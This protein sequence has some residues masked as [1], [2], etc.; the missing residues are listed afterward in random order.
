MHYKSDYSNLRK[1]YTL[2]KLVILISFLIWSMNSLLAHEPESEKE[3]A[4]LPDNVF[5]SKEVFFS[6]IHGVGYNNDG[7]SILV[8]SHAGIMLYINGQWIAPDL[9]AHDYMGFAPV[10]EGFYSSGHPALNTDLLNPLG[11]VKVSNNGKE[12]TS[13]AF[14]GVIDFHRMAAGYYNHAIYVITS[15]SHPHLKSGLNYTLDEGK[16]WT[17][18]DTKRLEEG[19]SQITVHPT[20]VRTVAVS[21]TK[22]LYLSKDFGNRFKRLTDDNVLT[23]VSFSPAGQFLLYGH[24]TLEVFWLSEGNTGS[25]PYPEISK[26]DY[27]TFIAINPIITNEI[28][29]VTKKRNIYLAKNWGKTW[30]QIAQEGKGLS[31]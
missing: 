20:D 16:T 9:P 2:L 24:Q 30:L 4:L 29:V 21:T 11:L 22:G 15:E 23:A 6:H 1:Q 31:K 26:D 10:D 12:L 17:H 18:S 28:V 25:I 3:K 8:A 13:L 27:I 19:V 7:K 14:A 5:S